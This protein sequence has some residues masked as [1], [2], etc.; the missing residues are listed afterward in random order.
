MCYFFEFPD[1]RVIKLTTDKLVELYRE[2]HKFSDRT[3]STIKSSIKLFFETIEEYFQNSH[4][5]LSRTTVFS[6]LLFICNNL[7]LLHKHEI[8][9]LYTF[10]VVGFKKTQRFIIS[11]ETF[12]HPVQQMQLI[13]ISESIFYILFV[14][15]Q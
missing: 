5:K 11:I 6:I 9:K 13:L 14:L 10:Q 8:Q 12:Q 1:R 3:I 7:S 2:N 15:I 4:I